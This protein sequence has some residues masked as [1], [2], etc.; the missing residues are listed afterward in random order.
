MA[1]TVLKRIIKTGFLNF[2]RGGLVSWAAV[3]VVTITLS[4]ITAII[5]LQAV[6]HFSLAQI[7]NKVDVTI[8][9]TVDAPEDKILLLKS[10]LEKLPEVAQV[11]YTSANEALAL[12]RERHQN[13]YPTIQAL[14]EIDDNPLGAY[15]NV[16][17]KEVSQYESIANF[18]KSDNTLVLGSASIIDKVNYHQNKLVIDRLNTIISGAQQL[19]FL[20]TLLLVI[21]SIIVTFNTIRLTIF[22]SKEEIGVMRLVGASKMHVRG[23]FMVEGVIYGVIATAVTML[24]F[25]PATVWLGRNMTNFLGIN[26]YSYYLSSF[27]QISAILLLSGIILGIISSFLAVRKYLNK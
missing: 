6:L 10:S 1:I 27:F 22:I 14:D 21:I 25:W 7:E 15:L 12:F 19:G 23:P 5:L 3:M 18:M 11:S 8:Y 24:L 16:K 13:D 2:K 26:M 17:A 20:I 9:F 4:V